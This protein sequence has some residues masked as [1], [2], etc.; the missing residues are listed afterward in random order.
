MLYT[1]LRPLVIHELE[2]D[3]LCEITNILKQEILEEQVAPRGDSLLPFAAVIRRIIQ[4]IQVRDLH[5]LLVF[6]QQHPDYFVCALAM[7]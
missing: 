6:V 1:Q 4:D 2:L 7:L 5:S 3:T